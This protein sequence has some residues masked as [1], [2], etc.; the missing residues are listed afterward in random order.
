M[1]DATKGFLLDTM[2]FREWFRQILADEKLPDPEIIKIIAKLRDKKV[3][4]FLS[5]FSVAEIIS[6][7]KREPS[8]RPHKIRSGYIET[9][10]AIT[11]DLQ[12]MTGCIIIEGDFNKKLDKIHIDPERLMKYSHLVGQV[13]D[14]ILLI[15]AEDNELV[16]V[17]KDTDV[18]ES[19]DA[20]RHTIGI[21][22]FVKLMKERHGI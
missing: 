2:I 1:V 6:N 16:F 22:H 11:Q 21:N 17:T 7:L 13:K 18:L 14:S 20:Y 19:K 15:I 9:M 3:Q 8:I 4:L 12:N 5:V 10:K